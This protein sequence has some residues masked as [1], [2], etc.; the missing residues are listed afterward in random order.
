MAIE[1]QSA[2]LARRLRDLRERRW[3]D[4]SLT[5]AE[6]AE[7]LSTEARVASATISSWESPTGAK[8][9]T[10]IRLE[11]YARFFATP[12]SAQGNPRL[13]A[14]A[15]LTPEEH[16]QYR[17]LERE[18]IG[19]LHGDE[20]EEED[21]NTFTFDEGPVTVICSEVPESAQ[22][23]LAHENDPNFTKLQQFA[24]LDAMV[25]LWGHLRA[26][27]PKLEVA[28][29]L[30]GEV[31]A[32][33]FST[34]VVLVGGRAW[35]KA[36]RRFQDALRQIP[37][38]QIN[39]ADY[40]DGEP[41]E[42]KGDPPT[43]LLPRWETD[44]ESGERELVEDVAFLARVPNPFNA[45]RTLTIC[46]GVHSRGVYGAVRCLTDRRVS[47]VN[48][49]YL[50]ERFPD[51]PFAL[52]LRVPVIGSKTL[53]PDLQDETARLYEWPAQEGARA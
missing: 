9:P 50:T 40:P 1:A 35:N 53:S 29:R 46:N 47:D 4:R 11:A 34:H 12:R 20:S 14:E 51:G 10:A 48:E 36:T 49:R 16:E 15:D 17:R 30:P 6:L 41:F 42:I 24:D 8:T 26:R 3:P 52:L 7:A 21:R 13:I 45:R 2:R 43:R 19:L 44:E 32:D 18:L 33:D 38:N 22:G 25:E 28:Y 39:A 5:Q 27:N 37:I 31:E 23:A